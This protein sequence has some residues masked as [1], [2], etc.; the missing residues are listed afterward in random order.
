MRITVDKTPLQ[1]TAL[2]IYEITNLNTVIDI[3]NISEFSTEH[4]VLIM[5]LCAFRVKSVQRNENNN[6]VQNKIILE[7]CNQ[8]IDLQRKDFER[9]RVT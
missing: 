9:P 5:P 1:Y 3:S 7:E 8:S 4:E 6:D 2:C